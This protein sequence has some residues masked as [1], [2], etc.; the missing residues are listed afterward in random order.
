MRKKLVGPTASED[1]R[2]GRGISVAGIIRRLGRPLKPDR[3]ISV[4]LRLH[5]DVA[6]RFKTGVGWQTRINALKKEHCPLTGRA[7]RMPSTDADRYATAAPSGQSAQ[8][9]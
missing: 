7:G 2:I 4:T 8:I 1:A 3:K 9:I 5:R 6:E